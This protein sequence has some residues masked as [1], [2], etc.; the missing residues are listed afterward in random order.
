MSE[1]AASSEMRNEI[2]N[3]IKQAL[4][5]VKENEGAAPLNTTVV[6]E[7]DSSRSKN[8]LPSEPSVSKPVNGNQPGGNEIEDI[9]TAASVIKK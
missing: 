3:M 1:T 8:M 6:S 2:R 9:I 5:K 4:E 7:L